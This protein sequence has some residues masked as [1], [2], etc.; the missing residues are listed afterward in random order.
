MYL[1]LFNSKNSVPETQAKAIVLLFPHCPRS[2]PLSKKNGHHGMEERAEDLLSRP[3][4][5]TKK[6]R[7]LARVPSL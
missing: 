1:K 6:L 2:A 5:V 3:S 7:T 4:S